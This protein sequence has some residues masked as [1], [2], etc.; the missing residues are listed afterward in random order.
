MKDSKD[1]V[2]KIKDLE[3]PP[4][5][6]LTSYKV[7]ALFTSIPTDDAVKVIKSYLEK[8]QTLSQRT[9]LSVDQ[10]LVLLKFCLNTT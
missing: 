10:L 8:D 9:A 6:K 5:Q 2:N 1:L 7:S 4:G 3:V